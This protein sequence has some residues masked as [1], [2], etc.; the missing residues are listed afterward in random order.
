MGKIATILAVLS[1]LFVQFLH[2][3]VLEGENTHINSAAVQINDAHHSD[4]Y[5]DH[6]N[7]GAKEN[8][9]DHALGHVHKSMHDH[10]NITFFTSLDTTISS[11]LVDN[12]L[13]PKRDVPLGL[14]H[15]PPVPPPLA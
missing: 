8:D 12:L 1:F 15:S 4:H 10:H 14:S 2:A 6:H 5:N 7:G 13:L 3:A 11:R 9:K